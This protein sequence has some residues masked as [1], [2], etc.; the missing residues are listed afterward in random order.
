MTTHKSLTASKSYLRECAATLP[1]RHFATTLLPFLWLINWKWEKPASAPCWA[2]KYR[3]STE[4]AITI[5]NICQCE[6]YNCSPLGG[7]WLV[8]GDALA[9]KM[10]IDR[11]VFFYH[12]S[13]FARNSGI[14]VH[15]FTNSWIVIEVHSWDILF[16]SFVQFEC[17][18]CRNLLAFL[19][20]KF[21]L[22]ILLCVKELTFCNS[23]NCPGPNCLGPDCLG[24]NCTGPNLP[25]TWGNVMGS[26]QIELRECWA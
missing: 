21:G 23:A 17:Q 22:K 6:R 3:S 16:V 26:W 2:Q 19:R 9:S 13:L 7:G 18:N 1:H 20:A 12:E 24:P 4:V 25:R 11:K 15:K 5:I 14:S 8:L 10:I